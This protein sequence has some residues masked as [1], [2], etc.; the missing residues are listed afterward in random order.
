[1]PCDVIAA[2]ARELRRNAISSLAASG[3]LDSELM[4]AANVT[5]DCISDGRGPTRSTPDVVRICVMTT[6]P[7]SASPLAT[8]SETMSESGRMT[9]ASMA[10][11]IP[12]RSSRLS[13]Y[14]PL[15][16]LR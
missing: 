10:L 4:P 7:S 3:T 5:K 13:R 12:S 9:L 16:T 1:M 8:S 11:L 14:A 6:I 2:A 15:P